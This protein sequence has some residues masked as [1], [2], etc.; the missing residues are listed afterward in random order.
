[1][2]FTLHKFNLIKIIL[3]VLLLAVPL[4]SKADPQDSL[5]SELELIKIGQIT[6]G[7]TLGI[8]YG[9]SFFEIA[10]FSKDCTTLVFS[11]SRISNLLTHMTKKRVDPFELYQT[12][13]QQGWIFGFISTY[14]NYFNSCEAV[15]AE[16]TKTSLKE[17]LEQCIAQ[18]HNVLQSEQID[19][20]G[21]K[22]PNHPISQN[23][24]KHLFSL[25]YFGDQNEAWRALIKT[26]ANHI[27]QLPCL[28]VQT[29]AIYK[30]LERKTEN[31][32]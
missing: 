32:N 9:Q 27:F 4:K 14:H 29:G 16:G 20:G 1:M 30:Y 28:V 19:F 3:T 11:T 31:E 13:Y 15:L 21:L 17:R 25:V 8:E 23:L 26:N 22:L 24:K 7:W 2:T 18:V 12:A 6:D 5:Y 10:F